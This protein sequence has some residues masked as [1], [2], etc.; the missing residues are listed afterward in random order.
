MYIFEFSVL[1]DSITNRLSVASAATSRRARL[2]SRSVWSRVESAI[3]ASIP[4]LIAPSDAL[5]VAVDYS[6]R[7]APALQLRGGAGAVCALLAA[8]F[9]PKT[10]ADARLARGRPGSSGR[11]SPGIAAIAPVTAWV[12]L[13]GAAA[14]QMD[15]CRIRSQASKMPRRS[16]L[17]RIRGGA[18]RCSVSTAREGDQ[19]AK[20]RHPAERRTLGSFLSFPRPAAL[21]PL[22]AMAVSP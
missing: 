9:I 10:R 3:T 17:R 8:R 6:E 5:R 12:A 7:R 19:L 20:Y 11:S 21:K 18:A 15:G 16:T 4:A 1:A 13:P 2:A 14:Q 22:A